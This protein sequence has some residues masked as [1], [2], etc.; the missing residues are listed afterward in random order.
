MSV[1]QIAS[2]V[3]SVGILAFILQLVR[4]GRLRERYAL[5]WIATGAVLLL[6]SVWQR[7]ID[8]LAGWF[9]VDYPPSLLFLVFFVFMSL[10]AL[11]LTVVVSSLEERT[12]RVTQDLALLREELR[13]RDD[14]AE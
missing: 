10:I 6:I 13:W 11:H 8:L 14:P 5:L 9:S 2:V 3:G 4:R 7:L 1:I 12:R